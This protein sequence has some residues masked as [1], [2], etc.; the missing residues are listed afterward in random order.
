ML[1][2]P[3]SL[4][5]LVSSYIYNWV[6][7]RINSNSNS[8]C[9]AFDVPP[10]APSS[11]LSWQTCLMSGLPRIQSRRTWPRIGGPMKS[12]TNTRK[13]YFENE[14]FSIYITYICIYIYIPR[15]IY[16]HY[17]IFDIG[18]MALPLCQPWSLPRPSPYPRPWLSCH[19]SASY[20]A[21]S[22]PS[23]DRT[24]CSPRAQISM[25]I[26]VYIYEPWT[27]RKIKNKGEKSKPQSKAKSKTHSEAL[28]VCAQLTSA[29]VMI[30]SSSALSFGSMF[31]E[32]RWR[33]EWKWIHL[34]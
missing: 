14:I 32:N 24:D 2:S 29:F 34:R 33:C 11:Q 28:C 8:S 22:P 3:C 18:C 27:K 4:P 26:Y 1:K 23:L 5:F 9:G 10:W 16:I 19:A 6:H 21:A 20:R 7:L 13:S 30:N 15:N 12:H 17:M 31:C 25:T